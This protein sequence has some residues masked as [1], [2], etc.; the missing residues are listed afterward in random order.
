MEKENY[1][2]RSFQV[3]RNDWKIW[4]VLIFSVAVDLFAVL[5]FTIYWVDMRWPSFVLLL[6]AVL[7]QALLIRMFAM[8]LQNK[9]HKFND[10]INAVLGC[11]P[12]IIGG[13]ILVFLI[14][15]AYYALFLVFSP[16][17]TSYPIVQ[18]IFI[19]LFLPI[20]LFAEVWNFF[21]CS[22][23]LIQ[24]FS[25]TDS[26]SLGLQAI[27]SNKGK[28]LRTIA[29]FL[30]V[31]ALAIFLLILTGSLTMD[32][33]FK[34]TVTRD[35]A[36]QYASQNISSYKLT[37]AGDYFVLNRLLNGIVTA[38][39][40]LN[41]MDMLSISLYAIKN[42][43]A[44]VILVVFSIPLTGLKMSLMSCVYNETAGRSVSQGQENWRL[45]EEALK[46][47]RRI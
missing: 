19:C 41:G 8:D 12:R 37:M 40:K 44:G 10:D 9:Q 16:L 45:K 7:G 27:W 26:L 33:M 47:S 18:G 22:I 43:L 42:W 36:F 11:L 2:K 5:T 35:M 17:I 15:M 13:K 31:E 29:P 46:A 20:F 38:L 6:V 24:N 32:S 21:T 23:I 39:V 4:L 34:F 1:W 3:L 28:I 25:A 30:L 14:P